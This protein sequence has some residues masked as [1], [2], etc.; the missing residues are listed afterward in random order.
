MNKKAPSYFAIAAIVIIIAGFIDDLIDKGDA[1]FDV[2]VHDTYYVAARLHIAV[3]VA[4]IYAL[5]GVGYWVYN[6]SRL[7][8]N[9]RL[10]TIHT[11]VSLGGVV[12]YWLLMFY[13][14][15]KKSQFSNF[16]FDT[17]TDVLNLGLTIIV[18]IV[19]LVQPLYLINLIIGI[20]KRN[21]L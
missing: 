9:N 2:N 18:S 6:K 4:I 3:F 8:L 11:F 13:Y 7:K 5:L 14:F 21:K 17:S 15:Y 19:A 12:V 16:L 1:T 20:I 10:T